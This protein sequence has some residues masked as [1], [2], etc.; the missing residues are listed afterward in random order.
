MTN[1]Y[2]EEQ[3]VLDPHRV[4]EQHRARE[5]TENRLRSRGIKLYPRDGDEEAEDL[6]D[7]IERFEVAVESHGGD[8]L[9]DRIGS[10]EPGNPQ[11]VPPIRGPEE[12]IGEYRLR[13][14]AAIDR[15]RR[16]PRP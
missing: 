7:A 2:G 11:F 3:Q 12:S 14:E 16:R 15:L 8:L 13:V 10:F 1:S 5:E 6:L 9:V 4:E